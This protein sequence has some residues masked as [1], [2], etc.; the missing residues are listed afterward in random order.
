MRKL[1]EHPA[2]SI[3]PLMDDVAL[4]ELAD[5]IKE[6]GQYLPIDLLNGKILDGRNRYRACLLADVDPWVEE[7]DLEGEDPYS[8]VMSLNDKRRHAS[9][10][11]RAMAASEAIEKMKQNGKAVTQKE[12]GDQFSVSERF[13]NMATK[14]RK[15]GGKDLKKAVE[16]NE[17]ALHT[18]AKLAELSVREQKQALVKPADRPAKDKQE[19]AEDVVQLAGTIDSQLNS[20]KRS[21]DR[22][23]RARGGQGAKHKAC[24]A[25][26]QDLEKA[27]KAYK[28]GGR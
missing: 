8:Y 10:Q 27:W 9:K 4:K 5:D 7:I 18:A 19:P 21:I 20:M 22:M 2:A 13:V 23:A 1:A 3:F 28:K 14:V 15:Q 24:I 26:L 17:V 6:K 11:Q 16:K 25:S 12:V